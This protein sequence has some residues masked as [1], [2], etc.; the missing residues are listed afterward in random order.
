M[1]LGLRPFQG[2]ASDVKKGWDLYIYMEY[3]LGRHKYTNDT[4]GFK[5]PT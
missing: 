2:A 1:R 4:A 5:I 3:W